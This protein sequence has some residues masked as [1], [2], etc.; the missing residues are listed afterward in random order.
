MD[1]MKPHG[2]SITYL[3]FLFIM[4][5]TRQDAADPNDVWECHFF[6]SP[7]LVAIEIQDSRFKVLFTVDIK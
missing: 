2:K 1:I 7:K 6:F 4:E 3:C 5:P